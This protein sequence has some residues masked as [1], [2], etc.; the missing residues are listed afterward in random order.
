MNR[1]YPF[2]WGSLGEKGSSSKPNHSWYRGPGPGSEPETQ[3]LMRLA[4]SEKFV[5]AIS[6][7]TGTVAI[8]P[9][10]T[11]PG[12]ENPAPN[13]AWAVAEE[14]TAKLPA[15]PERYWDL[16]RNLYPLDGNDQ[17]WHRFTHGTLALLVEGVDDEKGIGAD[18]ARAI[19]AVRSTWQLLLD[20][21]LEGP[22]VHGRVTDAVGRPVVADVTIA[23]TVYREAERWTS[24]CRDGRFDRYLAKPGRYTVRV[25]ALGAPAVEVPVDVSRPRRALVEVALPAALARAARCPTPTRGEAR[26]G[27][28]VPI[29]P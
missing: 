1:N 5:A 15:H 17:D 14:I 23:E 28:L 8:C 2:R 7:H 3:A 21:Y 25:T 26:D 18:R 22:S 6:F 11:I 9:P 10:Y 16:R 12:V 13:E 29:P 24:R 27:A 4:N 19:Q 20:R